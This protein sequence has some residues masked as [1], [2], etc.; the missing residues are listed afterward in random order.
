MLQLRQF[1]LQF[2]LVRAGALR[3]DVENQPG[4]AQHAA[5]HALFQVAFLAGRQLVIEQRQFGPVRTGGLADFIGF[6]A[7]DEQARVRFGA[8]AAQHGLD[9]RAGRARQID[10]LLPVGFV[11]RFRKLK[12]HQHGSLAA[13]RPVKHGICRVSNVNQG[14]APCG[15]ESASPSPSP[16]YIVTARAGTTVEIAC[17]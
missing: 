14:T 5:L 7:A 8:A 10:E 1:H 12:M 9:L 15:A 4:A 2:S 11:V 16:S 13:A 6:A 3:E 17:L